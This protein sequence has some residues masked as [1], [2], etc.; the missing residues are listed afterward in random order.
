MATYLANPIAIPVSGIMRDARSSEVA[1]VGFTAATPPVFSAFSP[2]AGAVSRTAAVSFTITDLDGFSKILIWAVLTDGSS[3]MVYNGSAFSSQVDGASTISGTTTKAVSVQH[4][5]PGWEDDYTLHALAIDADG[6][7]ASASSAY[8][9]SDPPA[10]P[11]ATAPTVALVSP[12]ADSEVT[13]A[14]PIVVDVTD[15]STLARVVLA[16]R[17]PSGR[18][19]VVHDGDRFADEYRG[20]SRTAITGG[21]RYRLLRTGG[22]P[23]APTVVLPSAVDSVGN[24]P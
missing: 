10:P 8:T 23:E 5:S 3:V 2:V 7:S 1:F 19:D 12:A 17:Y 11:D 16:A 22:W 13:R 9:L 14:T 24:T 4:D 20:S 6:A 21:F 18:Y 15:A